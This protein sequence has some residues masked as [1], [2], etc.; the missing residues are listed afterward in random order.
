MVVTVAI[1]EDDAATRGIVAG[2]I[3]ETSRFR[4]VAQYPDVASALASLPSQPPNV[5]L[6]DVNLPDLSGIECVRQLKPQMPHTQFVMVTVYGDSEHIF[7]ALAAGA[8][9]YLL[10]RLTRENLLAALEEVHRGG[11]PMSS[12]IARKVVQFFRSPH[13][14]STA[15]LE[16]LSPRE[17]EVLHLL[18]EGYVNKEIAERLAISTPTVA[19]YIRRIYEKLHVHSRAAA[20]G[21]FSSLIKGHG[22]ATP[23]ETNAAISNPL[24][25]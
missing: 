12:S 15:E 7:D 11:S 17:L 10:K 5:A 13:Q 9:G 3:D 16:S 14:S 18:A 6:V 1:I 25:D 2:W 8:S 23:R 20:I 22:F 21:K 4:C 19:T 24:G